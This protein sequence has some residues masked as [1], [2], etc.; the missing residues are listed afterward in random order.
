LLDFRELAIKISPSSRFTQLV[1]GIHGPRQQ[2]GEVGVDAGDAKI[3]LAL[4][5]LA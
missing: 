3:R 4:K 2:I 5:W 1:S